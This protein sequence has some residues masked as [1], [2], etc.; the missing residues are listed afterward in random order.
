MAAALINR[1]HSVRMIRTGVE[2]GNDQALARHPPSL[3]NKHVRTLV[4]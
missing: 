3:V 1:T 4:V 2:I